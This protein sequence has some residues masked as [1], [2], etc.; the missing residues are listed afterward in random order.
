MSDFDDLMKDIIKDKGPFKGEPRD[1]EYYFVNHTIG[2]IFDMLA[3][4]KVI[5]EDDYYNAE[6]YLLD[7]NHFGNYMKKMRSIKDG[8]LNL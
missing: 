1:N 2:L 5:S 8:K 3:R 6:V 7:K 4:L